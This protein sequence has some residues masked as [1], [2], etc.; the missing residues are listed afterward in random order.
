MT[1][2]HALLAVSTRDAT[3]DAGTLPGDAA[4]WVI[5]SGAAPRW[6]HGPAEAGVPTLVAG[7]TPAGFALAWART[8][9]DER[10][11]GAVRLAWISAGDVRVRT[12]ALGPDPSVTDLACAGTRCTLAYG[13]T[14]RYAEPERADRAAWLTLDPGA[15]ETRGAATNAPD[16][17]RPWNA[18]APGADGLVGTA[19][20]PGPIVL[21]D[22]QG[23]VRGDL[24]TEVLDV[25]RV[26]DA[27]RA[28]VARAP[29]AGRCQPG[30][31]QIE[32]VTVGPQGDLSERIPIATTD[33]RP[34]GAR[35]RSLGFP[36]EPLVTWLDAPQCA[37]RFFVVRAWRR[38][39][40]VAIAAAEEY[41]VATEGAR[42]SLAFRN[43]E[44]L[45]WVLMHCP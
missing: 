38:G 29:E 36:P 11:D 17:F 9:T 26:G 45:R 10:A 35:I 1:S 37:E 22:A 21:F 43:R 33:A 27:L 30:A 15:P 44:R 39:Q 31:W 40:H 28:V 5:E 24:G 12:L 20:G 18:L 6:F 32:L 3:G 2:G 25:A 41:D 14:D 8:G 42:I 4:T 13:W 16:A 23:G 34:R 7:A 19:L